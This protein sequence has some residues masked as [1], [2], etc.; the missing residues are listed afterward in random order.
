MKFDSA[1]N[2][3]ST[4]P[5]K[6][7]CTPDERQA[8]ADKAGQCGLSVSNFLRTVGLGSGVVSVVDHRK[9]D[10]LVRINGDLG[11]LGGLLKL[12]LANEAHFQSISGQGFKDQILATISDINANQ[13]S[14]KAIIKQV[15]KS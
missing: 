1:P 5:I 9:V 6:V 12:W 14:L 15:V 10:E 2:R 3:K 7:C 11:R 8:I 13:A 4:T